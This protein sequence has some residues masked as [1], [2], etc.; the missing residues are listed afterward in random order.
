M[1]KK[2][3]NWALYQAYKNKGLNAKQL[4]EKSDIDYLRLTRLVN[5]YLKRWK[6]SE[7]RTLS[8]ILR[9][10]QKELFSE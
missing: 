4:A 7:M 1:E 2:R 6:K 9:K 3:I 10:S 5:G 8:K